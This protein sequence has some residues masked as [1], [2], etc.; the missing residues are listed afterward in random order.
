MPFSEKLKLEIK[1][2]ALQRCCICHDV[3]IEIH[4][5]IPQ[6]ED[7]PDTFENAAPLCPSCH[8]RYGDNPKKRKFIKEARDIWYEICLQRFGET[9]KR[10]DNLESTL[11]EIKQ[12]LFDNIR[13]MSS[14]LPTDQPLTFGEIIDFYYKQEAND[15]QGFNVCYELVFSTLGDENNPQDI[16]FNKF[17]DLFLQVFGFIMAQKVV[18]H[19][20]NLVDLNWEEGVLETELTGFLN[21]CYTE[22]LLLFMHYEFPWKHAEIGAYIDHEKNQ[23]AFFLVE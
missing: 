23:L 13:S 19:C 20:Y 1:K 5:I 2:K 6:S 10:F 9:S 4:H 15:E 7:G 18:T 22:M 8:D 11:H 17:R 14:N 21:V 16:K 3:G 12:L